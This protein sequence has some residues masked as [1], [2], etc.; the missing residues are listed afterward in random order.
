MVV[1]QTWRRTVIADFLSMPWKPTMELLS[2]TSEYMYISSGAFFFGTGV[3]LNL[4]SSELVLT[5]VHVL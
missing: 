1:D 4:K 5:T 3:D 2:R